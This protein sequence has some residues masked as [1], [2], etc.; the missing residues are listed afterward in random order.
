MK[1]ICK[2][3][4]NGGILLL[5]VLLALTMMAIIATVVAQF[6]WKIVDM[7]HRMHRRILLL[8]E[9]KNVLDN[10]L[11]GNAISPAVVEKNNIRYLVTTKVS[12]PRIVAD[13][14]TITQLTV[15]G[16]QLVEVKTMWQSRH[17]EIETY[18]ITTG[19]VV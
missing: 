9:A 4:Q 2:Q 1:R 14:N 18:S 12:V 3:V 5:E 19:A 11:M 16:F 10:W 15:D 7:H 13:D 8:N 17:N 6:S